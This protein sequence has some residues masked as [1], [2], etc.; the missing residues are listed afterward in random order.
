VMSQV[1]PSYSKRS[2]P[3]VREYHAAMEALLGKQDLAYTSLESYIAAKVLVEGL[4]RAGPQPTR[5]KVL[6]ALD[7]IKDYDVGGYMVSFSPTNHNGS[8][9][10]ALSILG[11]DLAFRE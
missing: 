7:T 1:S 8:R 10:V 5:E 3:V 4:R 2:I 6:A 9:F 11:R